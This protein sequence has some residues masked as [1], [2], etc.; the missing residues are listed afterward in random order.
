MRCS[1]LVGGEKTTT[2]PKAKPKSAVHVLSSK[3][4][5]DFI[6]ISY[7]KNQDKIW[8]FVNLCREE[9]E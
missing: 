5:P 7:W 6:Q 8:L 3:F 4:Y 9:K 1:G 2:S